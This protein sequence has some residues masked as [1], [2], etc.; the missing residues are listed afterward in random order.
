MTSVEANF[1]GLV[2]STHNYSG[3]S[4]GNVASKESSGSPSNPRA[5][6]LQ[7]LA[8][9][10][11]L[12]DMGVRQGVLPPQERPYL[13]EL[14]RLGWQGTDAEILRSVAR[15]DPELLAAVS[16]ASAMWAANAATVSPGADTAD[17]RCHFTPANLVSNR[18]RAIEARTTTRLLNAVF[19]GD[20]F[21]VHDPLP[22]PLSDEGA[23]NHTRLALDHASRGVELFVY[24]A[25]GHTAPERFPGRQAFE[26]SRTV[27]ERHGVQRFVL[28]Q[29]HPRA[30]DAGVF[31]N[32]VIC[33]GNLSTLFVHEWAFAD[34]AAVLATL[35]DLLDGALSVIEVPT[36]HVSLEAAVS[37]Y[38]FNSQLLTLEGRQV[39]LTPAEVTENAEVSTFVEEL[40]QSTS[41][42]DEVIS[43]DL[44]QSMRNGGGPAC[45]RLRIVLSPEEVAAVLPSVWL[46]DDLYRRLVDWVERHYRNELVFDDLADPNL[47]DENRRSLDELTVLLGLGSVYDFQR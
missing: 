22:E 27:A 15:R 7:G 43:F 11:S 33:V 29:Q 24:G 25:G 47:L 31:H 1:D 38:L 6:A 16:S 18:H 37:T 41:P 44:R 19:P 40:V 36:R 23:A 42:I 28:A 4:L 21:V 17:G 34:Q 45:L 26:A 20:H 10:K 9:M 8:K 2:G 5:A 14:R 3:L 39:L 12:A 32:D 30:V 46:T 13:P 35:D